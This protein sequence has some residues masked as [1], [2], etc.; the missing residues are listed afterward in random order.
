M[1]D[2]GF[3]EKKSVRF[4]RRS[5]F[6]DRERWSIKPR[7]RST[8]ILQLFADGE[9]RLENCYR[10]WKKFEKHWYGRKGKGKENR[11]AGATATILEHR[12]TIKII[13]PGRVEEWVLARYT[14]PW[15]YTDSP[16]RNHTAAGLA[17]FRGG[18]V[19]LAGRY[20]HSRTRCYYRARCN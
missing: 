7:G 17:S 12:A 11:L 9:V 8:I 10:W 20:T 3:D 14:V 18:T 15:V 4:H 19:Q 13:S 2:T 6:A 16:M 5:F 1:K